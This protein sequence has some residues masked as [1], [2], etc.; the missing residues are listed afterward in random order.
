MKASISRTD[1]SVI[2]RWWW[3]VDHLLLGSLFILCGVG[4]VLSFSATPP[5]AERLNLETYFL[6]K[7]QVLFLS[8]SLVVML[9]LSMQSPQT[10][11]RLA[12]LAL[13][14]AFVLM[15][16]V[17]TN[18]SK[19]KGSSR[20]IRLFGISVQPSEF[21]KPAFAVVVAWLL[22]LAKTHENF[23]GTLIAVGLYVILATLLIKQPDFG[24][25]MTITVI[26][27]A[28]LFLSGIPMIWTYVLILLGSVGGVSAY[29]LIPHVQSR[30]DRFINPEA[31][32]TFQVRTATE[33]FKS[34]GLWG[35]GPG[36]GSVKNVLP[37]AHTDFIMAVAAEEFGLIICFGIVFL[38]G[39]IILRGF[40]LIFKDKNLF[41]LLAVSGLLIQFGMQA[42]VNIASTLSLIPT[43]GMTLPFISYGGSSLVS[44]GF[45]MGIVL[46]LTRKTNITRDI[47]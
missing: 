41:T 30:I 38:F 24:M 31:G 18:G 35:K 40:Y 14:G 9:T 29:Y 42:L 39:L 20:W 34:G 44:L 3:T 13:I 36:E 27:C 25:T 4:L 46:A 23:K 6:I 19:I 43:K 7:R 21:A 22:S 12:C 17:L 37:D 10:I 11:R 47:G 15:V 16:L 32:D 26:F 33:A 8:I 5:V 45:A 28:E 1:N 2:G